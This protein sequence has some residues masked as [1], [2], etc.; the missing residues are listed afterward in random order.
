M[1]VTKRKKNETDKELSEFEKRLKIDY[2]LQR[3]INLVKGIS[4]DSLRDK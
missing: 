1:V 2:Q 3:A 4:L